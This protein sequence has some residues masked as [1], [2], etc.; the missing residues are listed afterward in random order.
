M[1][2]GLLRT[3][4]MFRE[5]GEVRSVEPQE[6]IF[7][8]L[9]DDD[10]PEAEQVIGYLKAGHVLIAAMDIADDPFE[11]GRQIMNGST[12]LTDGDW[13]WRKDFAYFV[14]RH[15][16]DVPVDFLHLMRSRGFTVPPRDFPTLAACSAQARQLMFWGS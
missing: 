6:S 14:E 3:A 7:D 9:R 11:P 15:R 5:L 2:D 4:G 1:T 16:V 8:R 13:L 12:V 10:L